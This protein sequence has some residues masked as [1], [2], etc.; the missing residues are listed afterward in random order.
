MTIRILH[1]EDSKLDAELVRSYLDASGLD[2]AIDHADTRD[3]LL[4]AL[5]NPLDLVLAD[6]ALPGFD[7]V[8]ALGICQELIP[9]VPFIFV[10]GT[11][12]EDLASECIRDGATEYVLKQNLR[13]L[14][15]AVKRALA[16]A[17]GRRERERA[18]AERRATEAQLRVLVAELSHRVGNIL[19]VVQSIALQ[20]L[21]NSDGLERFEQS[22]LARIQSLAQTHS[23]LIQGDWRG[24]SL[25]EVLRAELAPYQGGRPRW[26]L[27][28]PEIGMN[29]GAAITMALI[30]HELATN[31]AKYGALCDGEGQVNVIWGVE[32]DEEDAAP[33]F[34]LS[35]IERDGPPVS[36]PTR[37]GFG[38]RLISQVSRSMQGSAR[39]DYDRGGLSCRI[40]LPSSHLVREDGAGYRAVIDQMRRSQGR[41]AEPS[42]PLTVH[43]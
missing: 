10:S 11:L 33:R 27:E 15:P 26:I 22:F 20:T 9:G 31:A 38:S 30:F 42:G 37:R 12:G 5:E 1:L 13:R 41:E 2:F 24:A 28:G 35:W 32:K 39:L 21:R 3:G 6:H 40:D 16:E 14:A 7:G 34:S 8:E 23:L 19:A 18:E 17:E 43:R 4:S 36:P 29:P 25:E